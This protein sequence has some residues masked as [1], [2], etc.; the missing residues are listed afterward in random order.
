M[1]SPFLEN[2]CTVLDR[3]TTNG[4]TI[5]PTVNIALSISHLP[6]M[7]HFCVTLVCP[8]TSIVPKHVCFIFEDSSS[9]TFCFLALHHIFLR[10]NIFRPHPPGVPFTFRAQVERETGAMR[11]THPSLPKESLQC[12]SYRADLAG[13]DPG[14]QN[15]RCDLY[16][17]L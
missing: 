12:D 4:L 17:T 2:P 5:L 6:Q 10:Q 3:A 8:Q 9:L 11:S 1:Y 14:L 16:Y 15:P 13:R 7:L